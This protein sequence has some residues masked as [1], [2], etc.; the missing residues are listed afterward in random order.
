MI[1]KDPYTAA[2]ERKFLEWLRTLPCCI[3]HRKPVEA[4]HVRRVGMGSG[5]GRK[6]RLFAI[7]LAPEVHR[8]QHQHG[9]AACLIKYF[10]NFWSISPFAKEWFEQKALFYRKEFLRLHAELF[11]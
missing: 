7:P 3:T 4:C 8:Y 11:E 10:V 2:Q 9:E 6:P 1:S 5:M